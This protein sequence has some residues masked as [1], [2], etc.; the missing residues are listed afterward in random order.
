VSTAAQGRQQQGQQQGQQRGGPEPYRVTFVCTGNLCRSPIAE[1]VARAAIEHEGLV[2]L[3][4]V[5]SAGTDG[6][7]VGDPADERAVAAL[8]RHGYDGSAHVA[9]TLDRAGIRRTDLVVAMAQNHEELLRRW[10]GPDDDPGRIRL[11]RSFDPEAVERGK[12]DVADP[13]YGKR[14]HF[15]KVLAQVEAAVPGLIAHVREGLEAWARE[16]SA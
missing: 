12:L 1:A 11:L 10:A 6:W 16:R 14:K 7:H 2:G 9:R 5:D 3:V 4:E 13:Y 8:E 15:E